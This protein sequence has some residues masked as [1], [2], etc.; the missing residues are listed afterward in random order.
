M[1]IE[2]KILIKASPKSSLFYRNPNK[3]IIVKILP[4][5]NLNVIWNLNI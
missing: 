3:N 5:N 1:E 4:G 2:K